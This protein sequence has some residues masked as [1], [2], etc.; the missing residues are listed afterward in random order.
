MISIVDALY[1]LAVKKGVRFN[2][3]VKVESI[4]T[5]NGSIAG[6]QADGENIFSDLVVSN[7]D[8]YFTYLNLL[9]DPDRAAKVLK[10]ER[11]SS[12]LI[13]YWGMAKEFPSLHLHNIFFSKDYPAEFRHLFEL[14]KMY[15]DPTVYINITSKME[16]GQAPPGKENWFVMLNA[17]AGAELF[18]DETVSMSKV[19]YT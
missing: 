12:A 9:K 8:V 13:F 4:L 19:P 1:K 7:V 11:S 18:T 6:V 17:P 2:F 10:R 5:R 15:A 3:G 14:K 16:P